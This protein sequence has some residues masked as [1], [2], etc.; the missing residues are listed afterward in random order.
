MKAEDTQPDQGRAYDEQSHDLRP[1]DSQSNS[2]EK[3]APHNLH[4]VAHRIQ[5]GKGLNGQWHVADGKG[6]AAEHEGRH[7]EEKRGHHG[8]L[9]SCRNG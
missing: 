7:E 5:V 3:D 6:E 9:L 2:L 1:Q 4:E 8:L